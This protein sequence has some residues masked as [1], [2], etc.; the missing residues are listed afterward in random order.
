MKK[1]P[2]LIAT[3]CLDKRTRKAFELFFSSLCD[4]RFVLT[5]DE[6]NAHAVLLDMDAVNGEKERL[7]YRTQ[8]PYKPLILISLISRE[9]PDKN[10]YLVRKPINHHQFQEVLTA[11]TGNKSNQGVSRPLPHKKTAL[12]AEQPQ[13]SA[14]NE[15]I[16]KQQQQ[17]VK[18]KE[19]WPSNKPEI[20]VDDSLSDTTIAAQCLSSAEEVN[21]VG[22]HKDIDISKAHQV[23]AVTYSPEKMLQ[24]AVCKARNIAKE[25]GAAVEVI[26]FGVA[27]II[28][29][30][31]NVAYTSVSD[32]VL[33]PLCLME[34]KELP[35][36]RTLPDQYL[37]KQLYSKKLK[38]VDELLISDLDAFIWKVAL[39]SSRGRVPKET[40][41]YASAALTAWPNFPRLESIPHGLRITALM[42]QELL[43]LVE[44]A[45]KL[46]IPQRYVFAFYSAANA[47]GYAQVMRRQ[48]DTFFTPGRNKEDQQISQATTASRSILRKLLNRLTRKHDAAQS[49][50]RTV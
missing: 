15:K 47:L 10:S 11:I 7:N 48:V 22:D 27:I 50:K 13:K 2:L 42:M 32:S 20:K 21:F 41:L 30:L 29:P 40:D 43:P 35:Q 18:N 49:H 26:A 6:K 12:P 34:T 8:N 1:D 23:L 36:L 45:T 3:L 5:S 33:R 39:W 24:G 19:L 37:E 31:K 28:D 46:N 16:S 9:L 44:V 38:D 14:K 17:S 4:G 25:Q